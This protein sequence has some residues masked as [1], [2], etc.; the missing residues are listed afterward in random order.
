M[1]LK[2]VSRDVFGRVFGG[3]WVVLL[4]EVSRRGFGGVIGAVGGVG[5]SIVVVYLTERSK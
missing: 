2:E 5:S 1:L 3:E 4:R